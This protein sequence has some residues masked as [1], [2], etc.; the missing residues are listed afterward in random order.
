M[1]LTKLDLSLFNDRRF[2]ESEVVT[3]RVVDRAGFTPLEV[4]FSG[5][6]SFWRWHFDQSG[7]IA[8]A[9]TQIASLQSLGLGK[10]LSGNI[11]LA[12]V[13]PFLTDLKK[14]SI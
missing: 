2:A 13:A 11:S 3:A 6:E 14:L 9:G 10:Y 7:S 1:L 12:V 4:N 5:F 8:A